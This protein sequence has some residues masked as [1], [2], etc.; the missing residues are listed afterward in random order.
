MKRE[1]KYVHIGVYS[2][3]TRSF[4]DF[5][6]KYFN[7]DEHEFIFYNFENPH[8]VTFKNTKVITISKNYQFFKII[9]LIFS[10][11]KIY[12][13]GFFIGRLIILFYLFPKLLK[14]ASWIIWGG[15][16]T[17]YKRPQLTLKSKLYEA[18][19]R[20]VLKNMGG[21][22]TN[23][24]SDYNKAKKWYETTARYTNFCSYPLMAVDK[25]NISTKLDSGTFNI[26][27]GNSAE[28]KHNHIKVLSDLNNLELKNFNIICPFSYAGDK[29]Y[30]K[31]VVQYGEKLFDENIEFLKNFMELSEYKR[32]IRN[33][34]IGIFCISDQGAVGNII[35]M[36][37]MGKKVYL[38][39]NSPNW[40]LLTNQGFKIFPYSDLE[41]KDFK[42]TILSEEEAMHNINLCR[43]LYSI[44]SMI[45][46]WEAEF[47]A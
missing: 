24:P 47:L 46:N 8:K 11:D 23:V 16:L 34:D 30:I 9:P 40:D 12:F 3:Y 37:N 15:G 7:L 25:E 42:F 44:E 26:I 32:V 43:K 28:P 10:A 41:K 18:M 4:Y 35:L 29:K 5:I 36:L 22:I 27:V 2:V 31:E 1:K 13:Q 6:E 20:K 39:K 17:A 33:S 38:L 21:I 14:K 45:K 19:R